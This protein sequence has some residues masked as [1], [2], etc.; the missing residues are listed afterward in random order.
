MQSKM[1]QGTYKRMG[2]QESIEGKNRRKTFAHEGD[3]EAINL[4]E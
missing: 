4:Q 1:G 2:D 3:L